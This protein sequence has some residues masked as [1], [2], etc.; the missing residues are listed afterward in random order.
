M[1][2]PLNAG[3]N[4]TDWVLAVT[5]AVCFNEAPA[6]RGGKRAKLPGVAPAAGGLQ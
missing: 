5:E 6:E 2:P 4:G 1:R 3:E